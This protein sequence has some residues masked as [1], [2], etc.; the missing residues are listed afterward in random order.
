[1]KFR[2]LPIVAVALS[3]AACTVAPAPVVTPALP[4]VVVAPPVAPVTPSADVPRAAAVSIVNREMAQRLPGTNVTPY[5]TCVVNNAT[6]AEL[7][8]I[9]S[10]GAGSPAVASAVAAIVQRPATS[11]CIAGLRQTA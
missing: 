1:M 5:T 10:L 9:A 2:S 8:D 11:R 7:A 3:L 4:P 6:Q